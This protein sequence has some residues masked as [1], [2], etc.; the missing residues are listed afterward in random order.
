[1]DEFNEKSK[2]LRR[3]VLLHMAYDRF[4]FLP[5]FSYALCV[6]GKSQKASLWCR[7]VEVTRQIPKCIRMAKV[8]FQVHPSGQLNYIIN[9]F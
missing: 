5:R 8:R 6:K 4:F 3:I 1:M 9:I 2:A 7:H